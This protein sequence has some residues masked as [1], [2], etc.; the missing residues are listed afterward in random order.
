MVILRSWFCLSTKSWVDLCIYFNSDNHDPRLGCIIDVSLYVAWHTWSRF[1]SCCRRRTTESR[2]SQTI[3]LSM[4]ITSGRL[5]RLS[6][7]LR[8]LGNGLD[9]SWS[10]VFQ[11]FLPIITA[12]W[13]ISPLGPWQCSWG[14]LLKIIGQLLTDFSLYLWHLE[15]NALWKYNSHNCHSCRH[16]DP[17]LSKVSG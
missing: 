16:K 4:L 12:L 9:V 6:T 7:M 1:G 17:L 5:S 2:L 13:R 11:V 10:I 15:L 3:V 8:A 14:I